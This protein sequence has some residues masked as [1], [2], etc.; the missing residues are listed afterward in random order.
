MDLLV[1]ND[2]EL[3]FDEVLV[4]EEE[5][6]ETQI[7]VPDAHIATCPVVCCNSSAFLWCLC[8]LSNLSTEWHT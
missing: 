2:D 6:V 7:P 1:E 4:E 5:V 3:K 8:L